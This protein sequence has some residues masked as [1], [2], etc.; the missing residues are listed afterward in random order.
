MKT[1]QQPTVIITG[2]SG[3]YGAG[4]AE[5]FCQRGYR[6]WITARNGRKLEE[7]ASRIGATAIVADATNSADWDRVI[8]TVLDATGRIDALVNNAGAAGRIAPTAELTD[9]EIIQTLSLNLTSVI[10]GCRRVAPVMSAQ[11][12]GTIVNI[13]SVCA[14]YSWPGWSIYSAAKAGVERFSK[15]LYLEVRPSGVRVTTL[16][17]SWGATE[18]CDNS[19]IGGHPATDPAVRA[20]CTHPLEL[21]KIVADVVETPAHLEILELTVVPTVQEIMPL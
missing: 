15:G 16:T 19:G 14:K 1:N 11:G 20:K 18:F 12:S 2:A 7:V 21:G 4:I 10:L 9:E 17:P 6:V 13:S 3:G 8:K 5:T